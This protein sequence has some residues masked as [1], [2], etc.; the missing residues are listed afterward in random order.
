MISYAWMANKKGAGGIM[1]YVG[2]CRSA[3]RFLNEQ[4]VRV[5]PDRRSHLATAA[6][7]PEQHQMEVAAGSSM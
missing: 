4:E 5:S 1:R 2:T 3:V 6:V 7:C